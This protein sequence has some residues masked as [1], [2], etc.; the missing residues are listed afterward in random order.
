MQWCFMFIII[1]THQYVLCTEV[2]YC[3]DGL[4][5]KLSVVK[6]SKNLITLVIDLFT[7]LRIF[8]ILDFTL[9]YYLGKCWFALRN[10]YTHFHCYISFFKIAHWSQHKQECERLEQQMKN[11]DVLNDFP[12][13]F[14]GEAT[15]QVNSG[16][17]GSYFSNFFQFLFTYLTGLW[18]AGD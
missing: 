5:P 15:S 12:F 1:C 3:L 2:D 13:T 8:C 7:I 16:L 9:G 14:T 11:V 17:L 18:K 4:W 6:T 10:V